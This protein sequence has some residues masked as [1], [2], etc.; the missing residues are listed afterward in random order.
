[1]RFAQRAVAQDMAAAMMEL[2]VRFANC[3][4]A[5]SSQTAGWR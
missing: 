5:S 3:M 1:M 2:S 4:N